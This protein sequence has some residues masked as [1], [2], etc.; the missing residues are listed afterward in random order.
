MMVRSTFKRMLAALGVAASM[1]AAGCTSL[2]PAPVEQA[3]AAVDAARIDSN[4]K[5]ASLDLEEAQR[6]LGLVDV[7]PVAAARDHLQ[8]GVGELL[9]ERTERPLLEAVLAH[10][11][12]NQIRA[13]A[14]LGINRN[15]LRKKIA[16]LGI[17]L[18]DR[19]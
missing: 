9:L 7:R 18:P 14:L 6:H 5:E 19:S 16:L 11:E 2:N 17:P 1:L 8:L 15:T 12:G 3:R 4:V 13:A 10:T